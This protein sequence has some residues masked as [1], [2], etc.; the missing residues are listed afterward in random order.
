MS[1]FNGFSSRRCYSLDPPNLSPASCHITIR[2]LIQQ[3]PL[4]FR[5]RSADPDSGQEDTQVVSYS[6]SHLR[7]VPSNSSTHVMGGRLTA[8]EQYR[9]DGTGG[10]KIYDDG[11]MATKG[12]SGLN[13]S[14]GLD[15]RKNVAIRAQFKQ[16]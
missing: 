6:A 7:C 12:A 11:G 16:I 2:P 15:F 5:T 4:Q 9:H 14:H 3:S 10:E 8:Q 13:R 1:L